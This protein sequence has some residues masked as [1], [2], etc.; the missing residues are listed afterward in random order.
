MNGRNKRDKITD[1]KV[2]YIPPLVMPTDLHK[3]GKLLS[4]EQ[5]VAVQAYFSNLSGSGV[6]RL[7][8]SK[9]E[10]AKSKFSCI[11]VDDEIYAIYHGEKR[12]MADKRRYTLGAGSFGTVKLAQNLKTG[13]FVALKTQ[14]VNGISDD[15]TVNE[16]YKKITAAGYQAVYVGRVVKKDNIT[17][18]KL[19]MSLAPGVDM[20]TFND[21]QRELHPLKRIIAIEKILGRFHDLFHDKRIIHRDIKGANVIY[22]IDT[23]NVTPIDF[24]FAQSLP[25][26]GELE[27]VSDKAQGSGYF[28]A[29]E[30]RVSRAKSHEFR[31][32]EKT[33]VY[34]LG[35]TMLE[36]LGYKKESKKEIDNSGKTK[37]SDEVVPVYKY[38]VGGEICGLLP[39]EFIPDEQTRNQLLNLVVSMMDQDPTKRP[40]IQEAQNTV[41]KIRED[42]LFAPARMLNVGVIDL[43]EYSCLNGREKENFENSM[44]KMDKVILVDTS[45]TED[46][47]KNYAIYASRLRVKGISV[48]VTVHCGEKIDKVLAHVTQDSSDSVS[49]I[50]SYYYLSNQKHDLQ[51][52]RV[53][54][55]NI[56]SDNVEEKIKSHLASLNLSANDAEKIV[57]DLKNE[58]ARLDLKYGDRNETV[59]QRKVEIKQFI[60]RL[61]SEHDRKNITYQQLID[62]LNQLQKSMK[63][64]GFARSLLGLFGVKSK[65]SETIA[66][67]KRRISDTLKSNP[68]RHA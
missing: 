48:D 33:E 61:E 44:R 2:P 40:T 12:G 24:G 16:E 53:C 46:G 55:I 49:N 51:T 25:E 60:A 68:R 62:G 10:A 21:T 67:V 6:K 64:A 4:D 14:T 41:K 32:T 1:V 29:P 50:Y 20:Q 65:G 34:S 28:M 13:E 54:H 59:N 7:Q 58:N 19:L 30:L 52:Q 27:Y 3:N 47:F 11:Q 39:E 22:D 31:Y 18:A 9:S 57:K 36:W 45:E 5:I 43:A 63:H 38:D 15:L 37:R 66:K 17:S 35:V 42:Y 56:K 8:K 26:D 23:D